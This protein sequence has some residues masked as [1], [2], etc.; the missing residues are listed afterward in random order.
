LNVEVEAHSGYHAVV[1]A[2]G[3]GEDF[4]MTKIT[5]DEELR[6]KLLDFREAVDL[7]D[8]SGR[9][10]AHVLPAVDLADYGPLEPQVSDEELDRRAKSDKW[11]TTEEVLQHL[12][13]LEKR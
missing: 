1:V 4:Q 10:L 11:C 13:N 3:S 5:V 12:R 7:Y 2:E 6:Q 8:E 9:L